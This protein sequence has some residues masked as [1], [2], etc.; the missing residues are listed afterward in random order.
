MRLGADLERAERGRGVGREERVAGARS[1]D[2]DSPLLEVA[3]RP[4]A[5]V[6]LG[7]LAHG[8]RREDAG[9][10]AEAL[11]RVLDRQAVE[12]GREHAG[13]VGGCAVHPF[14]RRRHPAVD[15]P[16]TDH[17]RDLHPAP[18]DRPSTS[19]VIASTVSGSMP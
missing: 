18:C 12:E 1:E 17:E 9:L 6:R 7:D 8:D 5:D 10:R 15:V 13:I 3:D 4:P 2:H 14:R 11:E 19:R 16:G